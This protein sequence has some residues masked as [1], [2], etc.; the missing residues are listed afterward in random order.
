MSQTLCILR[1]YS[2]QI[3]NLY[4]II[5]SDC[6]DVRYEAYLIESDS[7][8]YLLK[9]AAVMLSETSETVGESECQRVSAR[10]GGTE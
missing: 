9:T 4:L 5:L 3:P 1:A 2:G 7:C 10:D 6:T 8:C